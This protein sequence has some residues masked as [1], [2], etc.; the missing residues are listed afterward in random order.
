MQQV[1]KIHVRGASK[2]GSISVE[3]VFYFQI[4]SHPSHVFLEFY[5][6]GQL[7]FK[8]DDLEDV[9][10]L[11]PVASSVFCNRTVKAL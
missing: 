11:I 7:D 8:R 3:T 6:L 2:R 5:S 1:I 4:L 9:M 10:L